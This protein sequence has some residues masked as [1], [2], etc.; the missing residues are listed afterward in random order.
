MATVHGTNGK[1][2]IDHILFK[3]KRD[4]AKMSSY[5]MAV[6]E[7]IRIEAKIEQLVITS[8]MRT[9]DEQAS[10]MYENELLRL[11]CDAAA[12]ADAAKIGEIN[13]RIKELHERSPK[14]E[15]A[16]KA[17]LKAV[18]TRYQANKQGVVNHT[19]RYASEGTR[20]QSIAVKGIQD[21]A[22]KGLSA[23]ETRKE[24]LASMMAYI[25]KIQLS[26]VTKHAGVFA[27]EVFDI[28][29]RDLDGRTLVRLQ[30]A[31]RR[32]L[33]NSVYRFGNPHPAKNNKQEF[34]DG[35][36]HVEILQPGDYVV[37]SGNQA[38]A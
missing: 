29:I 28:R 21:G 36:Y 18:T 13:K 7:Q 17:E 14:A 19:V 35:V 27:L 9:A 8:A 11:Q 32:R 5:S 30:K 1:R 33:G 6:M 4:E 25:D 10:V 34:L 22:A 24:A 23:E 12:R 37:P 31:I 15:G 38:Y 20:V 2:A 26:K 3:N 16:L